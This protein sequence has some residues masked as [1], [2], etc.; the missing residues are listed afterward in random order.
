MIIMFYNI[1]TILMAC[2]IIT[3]STMHCPIHLRRGQENAMPMVDTGEK[4]QPVC[5]GCKGQ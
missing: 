1:H 4:A 2:A 3:I 5:H